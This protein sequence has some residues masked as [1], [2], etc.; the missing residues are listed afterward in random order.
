MAIQ[1]DKFD[2]ESLPMPSHDAMPQSSVYE[3]EEEK[4]QLHGGHINNTLQLRWTIISSTNTAAILFKPIHSVNL[5]SVQ[6]VSAQR[7]LYHFIFINYTSVSLVTLSPSILHL[8]L[9]TSIKSRN[10]CVC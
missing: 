8:N 2:F 7:S 5:A 3:R 1:V 10:V 6:P 4:Q 9:L